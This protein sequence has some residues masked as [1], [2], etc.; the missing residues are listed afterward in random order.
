[1]KTISRVQI[2][3]FGAAAM[4]LFA[5]ELQPSGALFENSDVKVIRA[6]E[7]AHVKGSFHD[8]KV[9]RVMVYLQSGTQ[10]FEYQD[11]RAPQVSEWKAGQ[12]VWSPSEGMHSPEVISDS[13]FNI[14][15]MELKKPGAGKAAGSARDALKLDGQHY[16]LEFENDQVRVLRVKLGAH[17]STPVIER[18]RNSV[19]IFLTDEVARTTDA[20]G[21]VASVTHKAG[22]AVWETP[23]TEKIEN[24]GEAPIEMV[25]VELNF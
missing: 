4:G 3:L 21:V 8:H 11:G 18:S 16:K 24:V 10:R 5:V 6:T 2:V 14:V 17:Q 22:E 25:L 15:E 23:V 7:K 12:V 1:M 13:P 19:A 9:N 20:N